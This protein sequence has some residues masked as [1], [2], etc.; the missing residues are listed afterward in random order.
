MRRRKKG[1][2]PAI[3]TPSVAEMQQGGVTVS[4]PLGFQSNIA[5][6]NSPN[7]PI[8]PVTNVF[9]PEMVF[10][11]KAQEEQ[12]QAVADAKKEATD[13]KALATSQANFLDLQ[14]KLFGPVHSTYQKKKLDAIKSE[15]GIPENF[16]ADVFNNPFQ[17]K[18]LEFK[19]AQAVNSTAFK[20]VMGQVGVVNKMRDSAS[21]MLTDDEYRE[22]ATMYDQYQFSD[23][24]FDEKQ[25]APS[26]FQKKNVYKDSDYTSWIRTIGRD[27]F[28]A[29]DLNNPAHL[30]GMFDEMA[31]AFEGKGKEEA[32]RRGYIIDDPNL[33]VVLTEKGQRFALDEAE[34]A[35]AIRTG[36]YQEWVN[37][38]L[39]SDQ[40][41]DQ[42]RIQADQIR[43]QNVQ[44]SQSSSSSSSTGKMTVDE[45]E[46]ALEL[47][48]LETIYGKIDPT[49]KLPNGN[50][51]GDYMWYGVKNN[52]VPIVK[53]DIEEYLQKKKGAPT[54]K[55]PVPNVL[56][57]PGADAPSS[58]Y[59]KL[60]D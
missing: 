22:W 54:T 32:I 38:K 60:M 57:F 26:A 47:Q 52:T 33:G 42:N 41:S 35:T 19:M 12:K 10:R 43:D 3:Y 7:I 48:R 46:A 36:K 31:R 59:D 39:Y 11:L 13:Q 15:Y 28:P 37:K 14:D 16:T 18:D 24:Y 44:Q 30:D 55:N 56:G 4:N 6:L 45:K 58:G 49:E 9:D 25:L 51:I 27:Y 53:K 20:E 29:V 2:R 17:L 50:T 34:R 23:S 1:K 5:G 40:I 21:K 8:L